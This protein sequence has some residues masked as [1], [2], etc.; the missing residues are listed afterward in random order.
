ML[1]SILHGQRFLCGWAAFLVCDT[2]LTAQSGWESVQSQVPHN[3]W[4]VCRGGGQ[5]V[6]V[7]ENGTILSSPEGLVWTRQVSGTTVWLTSVAWGLGN[8]IAVGDHGTVLHSRDARTWT[9]VGTGQENAP[10]TRLN[11]VAFN[12]EE[13]RVAGEKNNGLSVRLPP[14]IDWLGGDRTSGPWW[15]GYAAALDRVV[16]GGELGLATYALGDPYLREP[17]S[18]SSPA[19]LRAMSGVVYDGTRFTAVGGTGAIATSADGLSWRREDSPTTSNLHGISPFNNALVVV[20]EGGT[21]L[22]ADASRAWTRRPVPSTELLLAIAADDRIAVAVGGGGTILRSTADAVAPLIAIAPG[23]VQETLGGSAGFVVRASGSLP[24]SYQWLKN[25]KHLPDATRAAL[26]VAP[27]ETADAGRYEV[28]VTNAAGTVTSPPATLA[29][30]PAPA[31]IMDASFQADSDLT[32]VPTAILPLPDGQVLIANGR[33]GELVRL[34]ADGT[35]D[36]TWPRTIFAAANG[37]PAVT[38]LVLQADGRVLAAG[39]ISAVNGQPRA[40]LARFSAEGIL[41][42]AFIPESDATASRVLSVAVQAD[43]RILLATAATVPVRLLPDGRRDAEFQPRAIPQA[44]PTPN[45]LRD[46]L[47]ESVAAAPDGGVYQV[48]TVNLSITSAQLGGV[49]SSILQRLDARGAVVESFPRH[50]WPGGLRGLRVL[51]D[52]SILVVEYSTQG[53]LP[54]P[55]SARA[56]RLLPDGSPYPGYRAPAIDPPLVA[57]LL[58]DGGVVYT[59]SSSTGPLALTAMGDADPGFTG[60]IGTPS[61]IVPAADGRVFVAGSFA[62]YNGRPANRL[63]RLN[64]VANE[65]PH[66][67]RILALAAD[68]TTADYG[69]TITVWATVTG[70]ADLTYEWQGIPAPFGRSV[71][72]AM[73]TLTFSFSSNTQP[74]ILRLIVRN[75]RGEAQAAPLGFSVLPDAPVFSAQE[76]RVSAQTGNDL[77][78]WADLN[79]NVGTL[80]YDWRRDGTVLPREG[81][82]WGEP[83]LLRRGVSAA[84]AGTYTLTATN[85]LGVAT[86]SRPILVTVD[87]TSRFANLSTR[88]SVAGGEQALIAGFTIPGRSPRTILIRGIGP[89]LAQ[90][91]VA[92]PIADPQIQLYQADGRPRVGSFSDDWDVSSLPAFTSTGAFSLETGSK[93]AAF[94]SVLNPGSYTVVLT[95]KSG[96]SG[97]ALIEVYEYDKAASRLLNLSTRALVTSTAPVIAGFAVRGLVPKRVLLRVIGPGLAS[98]GVTSLLQDPRLTVKD[99]TGSTVA[100]NDNWSAGSASEVTAASAAV[101]AFPLASGSRDAASVLTVLPGNYTM[102]AEAV[103]TGTGIVLLEVYELP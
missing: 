37:A 75:P 33:P 27:L 20:G 34:R 80:E 99:A 57:A 73:P 40:N 93:D 32:G 81:Y 82:G 103:E 44:A 1:R 45:Q 5:F 92:N 3:L 74:R 35:L 84:D 70:S 39:T 91:G 36:S 69:E 2:L 4:G 55:I 95:G 49:R 54:F 14:R 67:P 51:D 8:F 85:I 53:G 71:V 43:G 47:V 66:A 16:L 62:L 102:L 42:P 76:T 96:E 7:G 87:D 28:T 83:T 56:V 21:I 18:I 79:P 61:L 98:F 10:Q 60:G 17:L 88:A 78:L 64:R 24:L 77:W 94:Y 11:V 63:A 46:W 89:G 38:S 30:L 23:D 26:V 25:G 97:T 13:F 100:S 22:T 6:A 65:A 9:K 101:G 52:G 58:A 12:R 15:R 41:D 90:F 72:T 50:V 68:K 48:A 29:L 86:V 19:D 31:A 59:T